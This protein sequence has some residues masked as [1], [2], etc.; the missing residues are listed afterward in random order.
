M[1]QNSKSKL[2]RMT[3]FLFLILLLL[4]S[5]TLFLGKA[6]ALDELDT[7]FETVRGNLLGFYNSEL[8][9]HA[10]ILLGFTVGLAS[11]LPSIWKA[12]NSRRGLLRFFGMAILL[13]LFIIIIYSFG[14]LLYW[15]AL[16]ATLVGV[17]RP[18][19]GLANSTI[20]A[21]SYMRTLSFYCLSSVGNDTSITSVIA[22]T[23]HPTSFLKGLWMP[24]VAIIIVPS[25]LL[26]V[27]RPIKKMVQ[28]KKDNK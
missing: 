15:S 6:L 19:V 9:S 25:V 10:G 24:S 12:I 8:V 21:T 11:L 16:S 1:A 28:Q 18:N 26:A 14:R 13:S 22:N 23:L 3:Y 27:F 2:G 17:T 4:L 20:D 7:H 5:T